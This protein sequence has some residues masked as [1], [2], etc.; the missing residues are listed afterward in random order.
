MSKCVI[1]S[2][3]S[4][5]GKTTIVHHLLKQSLGLEFSISACTRAIRGTEVDGKD[6]YFLSTAAF[7]EKVKNNEFV[8]WEEVYENHCYGTLKKEIERIWAGGKHVIFDV[9]VVGG[10]NLKKYFGDKALSIFVMPPSINALE[11][12]L[13]GRGTDA[14]DRI[15]N[16][17]EKAKQELLTADQ[18]D[19]IILNED[20]ETAKQEAVELVR[21]F[22]NA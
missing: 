20:L 5:A 4:G 15:L 19:K 1:F 16:R 14:E 17:L 21:E 13:K 3:P 6:Y 9:D 12:R 18:F 22:I 10:L 11:S 7:Q 8:E 2:A